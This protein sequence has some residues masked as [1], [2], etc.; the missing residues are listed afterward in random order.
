MKL[1]AADGWLRWERDRETS[2]DWKKQTGQLTGQP[3]PLKKHNYDYSSSACLFVC[4]YIPLSQ[5]CVFHYSK[6]ITT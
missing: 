5:E 3:F 6:V 4:Y 1:E 2:M